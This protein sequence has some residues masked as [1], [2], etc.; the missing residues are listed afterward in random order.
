MDTQA[1]NCRL[2]RFLFAEE[3]E[4]KGEKRA[5]FHFILENKQE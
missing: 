4:K 3:K 1:E 5:A 2:G